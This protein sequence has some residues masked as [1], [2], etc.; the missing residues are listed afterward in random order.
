MVAGSGVVPPPSTRVIEVVV[1]VA[2]SIASEKSM[3]HVGGRVDTSRIAIRLH[4]EHHRGIR[5]R[6]LP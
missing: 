6:L 4:G 2:G 5:F 3:R 1:T